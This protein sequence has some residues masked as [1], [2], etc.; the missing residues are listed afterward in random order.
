MTVLLETKELLIS[1]Y[2]KFEKLARPAAKFL[3]ALVV[4]A[5]LSTYLDR[6]GAAGGQADLLGR[7]STSA[8]ISA[9]AAFVPGSWFALLLVLLIGARLFFV[10]MEAA[11]VAF[12]FLLVLYLMFV[13]IYPQYAYF[14]ILVPLMF[15]FKLGY[16]LPIFAGLFIGP[17]AILSI[18]AGVMAYF[19]AG[20]L[21]GMVQIQSAELFDLPGTLL[22]MYRYAMEAASANVGMILSIVVFALVVVVVYMVSKLQ[23]DLVFYIAIAAGALVNMIGFI[24]GSIVLKADI[25]IGGALFGS[26]LAALLVAA[27]QFFRFSLDYQKAEKV[28]FE[29]DDYY[30][31]VKAIPKIKVAKAKREIKTIQ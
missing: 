26:I 29:D 11:L 5:R 12:I 8:A 20:E 25:S 2:K 7:A 1:V 16:V 10:S 23:R 22:A 3:L 24:V 13:R 28:Q 17:A 18:G 14:A 6:F 27:A 15:S 4:L 31:Y 21:P 19:M 9:I 30:Y